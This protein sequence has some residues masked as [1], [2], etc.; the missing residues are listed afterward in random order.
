MEKNP[1][2]GSLGSSFPP[3][4]MGLNLPNWLVNTT[5]TVVGIVSLVLVLL[6]KYQNSLL[7]FPD[8]PGM[9]YHKPSENPEGYRNPGDASS[10]QVPYENVLVETADGEKVHTWLMLQKENPENKPTL[11]Y[12]HGNAGNMGFRLPNSVNMYLRTGMNI[13]TMDYRGYGDST[14]VPDEN[15]LDLDAEAVLQHALKHPKLTNSPMILFGRSLGGAVAVSLAHRHPKEVSAIIVENTFLSI[16]AMVDVLI[17]WVAFAKDLV[18][19][20]GWD[21]ESKIQDLECAMMFIS[22]DAD[23]LVP[24]PQMKKLLDLAAKSCFKDFYSVS[25]GGHNDS[26]IK[27]GM[28]YYKRLRMFAARDEIMMSRGGKAVLAAECDEGEAP[29][30]VQ[31]EKALP[32][33]QTNFEVK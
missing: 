29:A 2:K 25:G 20:I 1:E 21:S 5:Y 22:G 27:A 17:P 12:F 16:S 28:E 18:L 33:M 8:I 3:L 7:Y 4:S 24:P 26:F 15:G 19:R 23:E 11:I 31:Q 13:L 6:Y 32:T 30:L 14:G 9:P 10:E